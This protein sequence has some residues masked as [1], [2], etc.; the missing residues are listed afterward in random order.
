M[1]IMKIQFES[2]SVQFESTDQRTSLH[3]AQLRPNPRSSGKV[4]GP[5][6]PRAL[7]HSLPILAPGGDY[8]LSQTSSIL[9]RRD[10]SIRITRDP[11]RTLR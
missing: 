5:L 11:R 7:T 2:A 9:S 6:G 3:Y 1:K 4:P 8:E 10:G